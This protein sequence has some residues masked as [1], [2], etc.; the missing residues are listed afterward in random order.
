M[1]QQYLAIKAEYPHMLVFYRMG[2]FYELFFSD[3]ERAASLLDITLTRRGESAGQPIPMAGVPYHAA[4]QYLAR[5]IRKGE[6][7]AICEQ[8]EA[9]GAS[10]GP[11]R[12]EV[13]RV[14]TPGT[15]TD[16][17]LL[18][19]RRSNLLVAISEDAKGF[20]LAAL[21]LAR[22]DLSVMTLETR[23]D[24]RAELARLQ[25]SEVLIE[26]REQGYAPTD[27]ALQRR[28]PWEFD[29]VAARRNLLERFAVHNLSAY[30]CEDMPLA[31][32]AAN[33]LLAYAEQTQ[34]QTLPHIA[35][36]RSEQREDALILDAASRRNLEIE[37]GVSGRHELTLLGILD[38]CRTAMGS[39][40]LR[41]WA[42][43]PPRAAEIVR[44]RYQAVASLHGRSS[45]VIGE[46]LAGIPDVE[47]ILTR[48]ALRSA[49]PR[50]L[51]G[52]RNALLSLPDIKS[53]LAS[54]DSPLLSGLDSR[55]D[56]H[57]E[58]A[59]LLQR[60]MRDEP[61]QW[62]RDGGVLR[63]DY[64]PELQRLRGLSENADG[65]LEDLEQR[66]RERSG[67]DNL[68]VGYNRVHGYYIE[69]SKTQTDKVPDDYNRRQTL[70]ATE[71]YITSELKGFE[72]QVLSARDKALAREKALYAELLE[73]L[74]ADLPA[75]QQ[76]AAALAELDV[77]ANL[78]ER[79][80]K[81]DLRQP[82]IVEEPGLDIR[83]GRH[84]VVEQV[85]DGPFVANDLSLD[86]EQRMLMITGPNMGGKSTYMRQNA[87]IVLMAYMGSFVPAASARIGPIDRIF[88]RIGAGDDLASGQSTFMVEMAEAAHILHHATE[89]SL[90]LLDEI[91]RG[92]STYDGLA[93]ARACAE[94]LATENRALTLFA[95]HY[96]EL[97]AV[98]QALPGV[99]NMHFDATEY[100]SSR[101]EELVFLHALKPGPAS[102]SFGLQVAAL[103]GVP[104][105]VLKAAKSHLQALEARSLADRGAGSQL[106][107][108]E[109]QAAEPE[110]KPTPDRLRQALDD[111]NPDEL[112]PRQA[113]D[114]LYRLRDIADEKD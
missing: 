13:V 71:R 60:A 52:L 12:R 56:L 20:G 23:D 86:E 94:R 34:K 112:S 84:L 77:L 36:I 40:A 10:K 75:L 113:L 42:G 93:L 28:P 104:R 101:G 38:R 37:F 4:E 49:R 46:L 14:I 17:A 57:L 95:T 79:A 109:M 73:T 82:E 5:L 47:R 85:L 81:L 29:A 48:I 2:D 53:Q 66:E 91:G 102:R 27:F 50:D 61:P 11:V 105:S 8:M 108:L 35:G 19:D 25:P 100:S 97:T 114:A 87:L 24:L 39:R 15:V 96:F 41:R 21:E 68:K 70:K 33:A 76:S 54:I 78:A 65:Y 80:E 32:A 62:L 9:P 67:I 98:A 55:V 3:A 88:T 58:Q 64:D 106:S 89:N 110:A 99:S 74:A 22:G 16:E 31:I 107:L 63:D 51:T 103:A 83:G 59:D 111:L 92:T 7:I 30:G 6:S 26:D 90:V 43:R 1:M 72:D 45:E 44:A 18:E 69:V